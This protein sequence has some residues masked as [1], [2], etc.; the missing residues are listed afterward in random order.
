LLEKGGHDIMIEKI[1]G[2]AD[3]FNAGIRKRGQVKDERIVSAL[4]STAETKYN[5]FL[6]AY[7]SLAQRVPQHMIA[8]YLGITPETISRIRRKNAGR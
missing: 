1:S 6:K 2:Y 3:M 4:A 8:S 7:P 5:D